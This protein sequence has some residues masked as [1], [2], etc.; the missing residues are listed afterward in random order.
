[1]DAPPREKFWHRV[2]TCKSHQKA[3][4]W[5]SEMLEHNAERFGGDPELGIAKETR[6]EEDDN[7]Y[8]VLG[9]YGKYK[10]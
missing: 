2:V 3:K 6:I 5:A 7:G 9:W 10:P 1:M 8:L 4:V